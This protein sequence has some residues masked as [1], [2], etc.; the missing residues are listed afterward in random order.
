[1]PYSNKDMIRVTDPLPN[2][3]EILDWCEGIKAQ[4]LRDHSRR[5]EVRTFQR[6]KK[7]QVWANIPE[8]YNK[9][10]RNPYKKV[11]V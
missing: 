10:N 9:W 1:M 2:T 11:V 8:G 4:I 5:A 3:P 7:L 6:K